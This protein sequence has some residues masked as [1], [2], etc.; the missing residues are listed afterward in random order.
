MKSVKPLTTCG[1]R[2]EPELLTK[3]KRYCEKNK[4]TMSDCLRSYIKS[5]TKSM[6]KTTK[7]K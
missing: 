6:R 5:Q 1:L 3:F 2:L 4:I 7:G